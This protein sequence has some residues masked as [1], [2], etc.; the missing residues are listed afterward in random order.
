MTDVI[1][2][3]EATDH[4]AAAIA[5]IYAYY[6][7]ETIV[8]FEEEVIADA[9]MVTRIADVQGA[10]LPWIVAELDDA[11]V[12]YA[13]ATKWRARHGYR[14]S[15]ETTVYVAN[16]LRGRGIGS[17]LYCA[18]LPM[19]VDRGYHAA[20]GGIALP[21]DASIVLHEKF[22]F[23]Q[24]A[25]FRETGMK[26]DRWIDTGYWEKILRANDDSAPADNHFSTERVTRGVKSVRPRVPDKSD[27]Y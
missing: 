17:A 4:D 8:T 19:L 14:F 25:H 5:A 23:S 1:H 15:V 7:S 11:V 10:G 13:Y 9:D 2:V 27:R 21:N 22:G 6:V 24:V 3:R 18:L 20:M 26:F 16:G 12:G